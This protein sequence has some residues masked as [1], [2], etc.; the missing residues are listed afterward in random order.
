MHV[1]SAIIGA[2]LSIGIL[3]SPMTAHADIYLWVDNDGVLHF[4]NRPTSSDFQVYMRERPSA[5]RK[6][7]HHSTYDDYIKEASSQYGVSF[8]LLKAMIR[9]ESAFNARA[10][11]KKGAMGLMQIMPFNLKRLEIDDAF[12]PRQNIMGGT[13]YF[14]TLLERFQGQVSLALAAYNAGPTK[15]DYYQN[16]PP[17]AETEDYVR[18][19]L[20]YYYAYKNS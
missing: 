3:L 14:K 12:N 9:A 10:V 20:K 19:V 4:T 11:S 6:K 2:V 8:P 7:V 15:V 16:I 5:I 18:K 13:R 17:F 1:K